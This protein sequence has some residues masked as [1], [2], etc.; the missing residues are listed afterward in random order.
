MLF[1]TFYW[2]VIS[3]KQL[4][5]RFKSI[6]YQV[7]RAQADVGSL[8]TGIILNGLPQ[9]LFLH[10]CSFR[11]GRPLNNSFL[12]SEH[13]YDII[14]MN[15]L[16]HHFILEKVGLSGCKLLFLFR[17]KNTDCGLSLGCITEAVPTTI[18]SLESPRNY[19]RK[20]IFPMEL[21]K[22]TNDYCGP[23][24]TSSGMGEHCLPE[25]YWLKPIS[26]WRPIEFVNE[27]AWLKSP[28]GRNDTVI[29]EASD[30]LASSIRSRSWEVQTN[31]PPVIN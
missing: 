15:T 24:Y 27:T 23:K 2:L 22:P 18:L 29:K 28:L 4:K 19:S 5:G 17:L 9:W 7:Q 16:K 11:H 8:V 10:T 31:R 26:S 14:I 30:N 25:Y 20:Q 3:I 6:W 1:I 21:N 12:T 13:W